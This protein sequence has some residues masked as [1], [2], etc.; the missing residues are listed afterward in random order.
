MLQQTSRFNAQPAERPVLAPAWLIVLLAGLIG[1]ALWLLYPRQDLERRLA[2]AT[3]DT[4]I[5]LS[6]VYLENLLRS[7]PANMQLH[8]LLARQHLLLGE[9]P[10]A[11]EELQRVRGS[12]DPQIQR[13]L[14]WLDWELDYAGYIALAADSEE[15]ARLR[16][17]MKQKLQALRRYDWPADRLARLGQWGAQ[18]HDPAFAQQSARELAARQ[19]DPEE[20]ARLY[21]QAARE[22]LGVSDYETCAQL[23]ILARRTTT[24]PQHAKAYFLAA[25]DALQSGNRL[26]DA[27]ALGEREIGVLIDDPQVL[28]RMTELAR[29][30]ARPDVADRY[31]R[32]LLRMALLRPAEGA[33]A[34]L[35]MAARPFMQ[36]AALRAQAPRPAPVFDD[37]AH[38]LLPPGSMASPALGPWRMVRAA[39]GKA[40]AQPHAPGLPFDDKVYSLAYEVFLENRKQ[41]DAWAIARAA[42]RQRPQDIAWRER[43]A[44][45][46]EW[47]ERAD[48]ALENW[49]AIAQQTQRPDAWQAVLRI[50]PGQFDDAALAQALLYQLR[51]RPSDMRLVRELVDAYERL[52]EPQHA[53]DYLQ[54]HG[55]GVEAQELLAQLAERAGQPELALQ[56]WRKLFAQPG[57][58]T[59]QRAMQAA[60][61]ALL[62]RQPQL[63]LPWLEAARHGDVP[64]AQAQDY[65][66]LTGQLADSRQRQ[67]LAVEAYRKLITLPEA[68]PSDFEALVR[69]LRSD[70]PLEAARIS[71]MAWQRYAQPEYLVDALTF[72]VSRSRWADTARLVHDVDAPTAAQRQAAAALLATP[73][74]LRLAGTY[75]QNTG[76]TGR[77]RAYFE[78]GLRAAPS[79]TDM[80]SALLWLFI[81]SNDAAALRQLLATHEVRWSADPELHDSLA[82]AYQALSLPQTA[83]DR[84]LTPQLH[85]RQSDFLWL[86][87]YADALDQNQQADQAWRLRRH[88]L[89]QQRQQMHA[90]SAAEARQRWLTEEGLD[91]TRR[92]ARARLLMTQRPGDPALAILRELLRLDQDAEDSLSNAAAETAIG[93]L[94]DAGE[95]T[96]ER[97]YLWHQYARA[98]G[99]RAN[100][101]LW[102]DI[103]VALAEDDKA[104]TGQLLQ[105][106]DE[107][108]PRYD[109]V[110]AA[111]AVHDVRLAQS[112]AFET[113]HDQHDD[114]P[115]HLQ[116]TENLLAFSDQAGASTQY[117]QLGGMDEVRNAALLHLAVSPR[118]SLDMELTS[119][120]R[121]RTAPNLLR[122]VPDEEVAQVLVRWRHTDGETQLRAAARHGYATTYPR[123]L[124]HEQRLDN[125]LTLGGEVG[126]QQPSEES[127]ALRIGGMKD[128]AAANLRYQ[129]TRQDQFTLTHW[130]ERYMLQTGAVV[131]TGRHSSLQYSHTYRQDAPGLAFGA[132]WSRHA[133]ERRD[134]G[135]F[136]G[137][138]GQQFQTLLPPGTAMGPDL[139][140]PESFR[141]YGVELSSNMRYAQEYT[142]AMRPYASVSRTWHSS[143]GPGYGLRLGV[144]GSVFGPDHLNLDWSLTKSG[145]QSLGLT[146]SLQLSYRLHF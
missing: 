64:Q 71:E 82:S 24:D 22:A 14:A 76:A 46:S 104:A 118:L 89:A 93:W 74:Y 123:L 18:F 112:A 13:E 38:W 36:P 117:S 142:R 15:R 78:N 108:L 10:E 25:L 133:F 128:R 62:L 29:A 92:I 66:R 28:L 114:A 65:W 50:A 67:A 134:P 16:P 79:S 91:T 60:V 4:D 103:T 48:V 49:L 47:T 113:Q 9:L 44:R 145:V 126:T 83:L 98:H 124:A 81:D 102:A 137:P 121:L 42:V 141:F 90:A 56:Q 119:I 43:L 77:A 55:Q 58:L 136:L 130:A 101:P 115:L 146:R 27:V 80:R 63:G 109:R 5:A 85:A 99:L 57:T 132:F 54:A 140:L 53:I 116:L 94:Q 97:G 105:E 37:G 143:L 69:L 68:E 111:A 34:P 2:T 125:R 52:G 26:A 11:R 84:Y 72:H 61:L 131:G 19:A 35:Q 139:F 6:V 33:P 40:A 144:S 39:E 122:N 110:N 120:R 51:S 96:A 106:F 129:A 87:N 7:D 107:R 135:N 86:M 41:D 12:S 75:Y 88:L 45:V 59:P 95:Y 73:E 32:K 138:Q 21:E 17:V 1:G 100:R 31:V 127:L 70:Y 30:A 20:A 23:Y 8:L 3:A